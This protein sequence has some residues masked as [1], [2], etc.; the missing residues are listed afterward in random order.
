M[1]RLYD[2]MHEHCL[3]LGW[4]MIGIRRHCAKWTVSPCNPKLSDLSEFFVGIAASRAATA[5][6]ASVSPTPVAPVTE[7]A[8]AAPVVG[9]QAQVRKG[10]KVTDTSND[11]EGPSYDGTGGMGLAKGTA[12]TYIIPGMDEMTP[13]EYRKALQKSVSDRQTRRRE[14]REGVVGNRAALQYLDQLGYGGASSNWK[15]KDDPK[16]ESES[17]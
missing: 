10:E 2:R 16:D 14:S 13:E 11:E 8:P 17:K 5:A 12:N 7:S 1:Y 15:K 3:M 9:S 6:V 4:F